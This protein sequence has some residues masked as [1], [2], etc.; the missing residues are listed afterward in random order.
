MPRHLRAAGRSKSRTGPQV[1]RADAAVA[2]LAARQWGIV[3]IDELRACGLSNREIATR[4]RNSWLHRLYRGVYAVGHPNPPCEGR[5]L[6]AV[7]ACGSAAVLSHFGAAALWGFVEWDERTP[8]VTVTRS[9]TPRH[10]GLRAHRTCDL[11]RARDVRSWHG[12]PI[13]APAR[14]IVDMAADT[15]ARRLRAAVRR[16]QSLGLVRLDELLEALARLGP[17]GGTRKL[18][19]IIATGPAPTRSVL[20]D[21]VLDLMLAA[22]FRRPDVNVPL[23][24]D[25]RRV[26]PDFRWPRERVVVEAD[27]AAWHDHKLAREDDAERQALLEAHGERVVRVTWDQAVARPAETVARLR[28]AGA[29]SGDF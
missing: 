13:T 17:R 16:A 14:T 22:G 1:A 10:V 15:N 28:A 3:S 4:V 29:P 21:V 6:A 8:E 20:E 5:F 26:I 27:G 25:G 9:R 7:K 18:K 24:L 19:R 12:I 2:R 11:D 23:F